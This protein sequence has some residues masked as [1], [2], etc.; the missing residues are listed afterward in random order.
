MRIAR[1]TAA[2]LR[3]R[4]SV[5][6]IPSGGSHRAPAPPHASNLPPSTRVTVVT[7]TAQPETR[8]SIKTRTCRTATNA[9][10]GP[11][12]SGAIEAE[13]RATS[14]LI[15]SN[16]LRVCPRLARLQGAH[17]PSSQPEW[18]ARAQQ[19]QSENYKANRNLSR[20]PLQKIATMHAPVTNP[21]PPRKQKPSG[22]IRLK[23]SCPIA[24]RSF[25]PT[26]TA[27]CAVHGPVSAPSS[28]RALKNASNL[29]TGQL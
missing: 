2:Y 15:R 1:G 20:N 3:G 12:R 25:Q 22:P 26:L 28:G 8:K 27:G 21:A 13:F 24:A 14:L 17:Q 5:E 9:T 4:A 19:N 23:C 11:K 7:H 29:C 18:L 10:T 6:T 16:C